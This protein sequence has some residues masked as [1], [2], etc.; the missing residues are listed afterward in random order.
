MPSVVA[1]DRLIPGSNAISVESDFVAVA[2]GGEGEDIVVD[3][4]LT[5]AD[6]VLLAADDVLLAALRAF[7]VQGNHLSYNRFS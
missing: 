6:D 2:G 5:E 4:V 3:G 7:C 1:Q